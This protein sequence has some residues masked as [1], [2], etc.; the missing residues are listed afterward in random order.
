MV[1]GFFRKMFGGPSAGESVATEHA[2]GRISR[3]STGFQEFIRTIGMPEGQRILDLGPTSPSNISFIT[4]LGHRSYN[5]DILLESHDPGLLIPGEDGK[6]K[7]IDVERF[8]LENLNHEKALFD[9]V[10]LWDVPD[11]LDESLVKPV[12]ERIHKVTKPGAFLL[13]FFHTRD[14]GPEAPYYRYHIAD[15]QTLE[16]QRG[17]QF[18]LKRVFNNRHIE[19]LFHD[20]ASLKFF[21]GRDNIRE[22]LVVR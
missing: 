5:E 15:K 21:L 22:V 11:Y 18:H 1:S 2:Q 7:K 8:M 9:A 16:L 4:G 17:P 14:A 10:L 6:S 19:N 13:G 3:R 12:I 20:Y